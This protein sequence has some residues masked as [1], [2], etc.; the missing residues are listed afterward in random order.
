[1]HLADL[2]IGKR[3]NE[4]SLY[5]DQEYILKQIIDIA[6]QE[7][8]D[9]AIISG[10][11]YDKAQPAARAVEILSD[12]LSSLVKRN[13]KV[14]LIAGNHDSPER[15]AYGKEIFSKLNLNVAGKLEGLPE[16]VTIKDEYGPVNFV[17]LP[18]F[19]LHELKT[20]F[21]E[22][23][24]Q[25]DSYTEA[26]KLL[27]AKLNLPKDE[28]KVLISHQFYAGID[29]VLL[30]ESERDIVGGLDAIDV[31]ILSDYTYGAL[32]HIH[33]PQ[34]L[35][36]ENIRYAGSPLAYSYSEINQNKSVPIVDLDERLH[37]CEINLVKL[38][39]LREVR[40][41]TGDFYEILEEARTVDSARR[42]DYLKIV[43]TNQERIINPMRR[44][45]AYYPNI[46]QLEFLRNQE[47]TQEAR[48]KIKQNIKDKNFIELFAD[49]Y[50]KQSAKP[51][52][53][54][55][56]ERLQSLWNELNLKLEEEQR[57]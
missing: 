36:Q 40:E 15:I 2:H 33:R 55:D 3:L 45:Q 27:L 31:K 30:A 1:M 44:L 42:Q 11:V 28:R 24:G 46:V 13:I 57:G 16:V 48:D 12:F 6:E 29:P 41:I 38:K 21:P 23:I 17:L 14:L 50:Q 8:P 35:T 56:Q 32:G 53:K 51:L 43:L 10:D 18:F 54:K 37:D 7:K 34:K 25:V 26:T 22:D 49:F 4:F 20:L 9:I 5:E 47:F 52:S 39:P 19:R